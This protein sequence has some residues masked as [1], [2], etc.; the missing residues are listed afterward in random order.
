MSRVLC[1]LAV[2]LLVVQG[3]V[4][5]DHL[6]AEEAAKKGTPGDGPLRKT[7]SDIAADASPKPAEATPTTPATVP[8]TVLGS[9]EA[10]YDPSTHIIPEYKDEPSECTDCETT[11]TESTD[12][13][14]AQ[15]TEQAEGA[16]AQQAQQAQQTEQAVE[17]TQEPTE[18][19]AE[20]VESQEA[21]AAQTTQQTPVEDDG[22][23]EADVKDSDGEVT[24]EAESV[25]LPKDDSAYMTPIIV[26]E[27]GNPLNLPNVP[28][29][30]SPCCD[31]HPRDHDALGVVHVVEG[32][33]DA[34]AEADEA[35]AAQQGVTD[36]TTEAT[37][38]QQ[39][40]QAQ[41]GVEA[42]QAQQSQLTAQDPAL[43]AEEAEA[44][45]NEPAAA[46][47]DEEAEAA[48]AQQAQQAQQGADAQAAQ[49]GD[50]G[51][52]AI[53]N[54]QEESEEEDLS[55]EEPVADAD[56]EAEAE[57]GVA[58]S[59]EETIATLKARVSELE[60]ELAAKDSDVD[61]SSDVDADEAAEQD[62]VPPVEPAG[63]VDMADTVS[64]SNEV[65]ANLEGAEEFVRKL[66]QLRAINRRR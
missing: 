54:A 43:E 17:S 25:D 52:V 48:E 27:K 11:E 35:A 38:A 7:W 30:E 21:L 49:P 51:D 34:D 33:A 8:A 44:A 66:A 20:A 19:Q 9:D 64:E 28:G 22:K 13:E 23:E 1:L 39:A 55:D 60:T 24:A 62:V 10:V 58:P 41:Q 47:D 46:E 3:A 12:A 50:D 56:A 31:A 65:I 6:T 40:Q 45:Q 29:T 53:A 59:A 4:P 42:Q 63:D 15:Q 37:E 2:I 61:E 57:E 16:Q 14:A 32:E 18:E 26:D 5:V 36:E